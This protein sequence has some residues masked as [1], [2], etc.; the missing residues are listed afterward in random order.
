MMSRRQEQME[1]GGPWPEEMNSLARESGN[2]FFFKSTEVFIWFALSESPLMLRKQTGNSWTT[3][4]ISCHNNLIH[5]SLVSF[6][7]FESCIISVWIFDFQACF[8]Q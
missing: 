7:P 8:V 5:L 6:D 4:W 2:V 3:L 1:K